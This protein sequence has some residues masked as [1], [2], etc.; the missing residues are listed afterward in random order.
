MEP[1]QATLPAPTEITLVLEDDL[2]RSRLTVF[3]RLVMAIPHLIL[4]SLW[5]IAALVAAVV[6]WFAVLATGRSP[7]GLHRFLVLYIRYATRV[8]A[9]VDLVANPFTP[10]ATD[11]P[12]PVDV[13]VAPPRRQRRWT[14]ALRLF[15]GVPVL[16][17]TGV[18]GA[19][20][21][22]AFSGGSFGGAAAQ[23]GGLVVVA[24]FLTWFYALATGRAPRGLRDLAAYG[25]WYTAQ[26]YGYLFVLTDRY[27]T[28]DPT[29]CWPFRLPPHPV[30][31][32]LEDEERR[33]RFTVFFRLALTVPHVVWLTL[34]SLA[35][36]IVVVPHWLVTVVRGRA[37]TGLHRFLAA[38]VRYAAHVTAFLYLVGNP[39]PGF[40]GAAGRYPVDIAIDAAERQHRGATFFRLF[41]ALPALL[42]ASAYSSALFVVAVLGWFAALFTGRMPAGLRR[43][44][45]VAVR[46]EAQAGAYA[47]LLT[48]RY[49]D[50]GPA[51]FDTP[52]TEPDSAPSELAELVLLP[53][54]APPEPAPS[55]A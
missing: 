1:D 2:R 45:A 22:P 28:C 43:L 36:A 26:A 5:T 53:P 6:N 32:E 17:L 10:F 19:S 30:R 27:P 4:L 25:L 13:E 51:L 31:L 18:L 54:P 21:T 52:P 3:F 35:V 48:D 55:A 9:F 24:A 14:V 47:L 20:S 49:P 11:E 40:T 42:V 50:A 12:Y 7:A 23:S 38:Y 34:W 33:S 15:L 37:L 29:R 39:F 46:Y 44:G 16:A 41:L 8:S